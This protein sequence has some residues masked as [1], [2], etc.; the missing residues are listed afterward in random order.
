MLENFIE[1]DSLRETMLSKVIITRN[2]VFRE[3]SW[4]VIVGGKHT[5]LFF[6]TLA[7]YSFFTLTVGGN[8]YS[9]SGN[10]SLIWSTTI[11]YRTYHENS[12]NIH[13]S[14]VKKK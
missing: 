10:I 2:Y 3:A 9:L 1:L 12:Q 8:S 4:G 13:V 14:N 6:T 7:K 5:K 11:P